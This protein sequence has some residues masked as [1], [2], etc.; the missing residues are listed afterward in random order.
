VP[1]PEDIEF[2]NRTAELHALRARIPPEARKAT[3]TF[4]RSPSGYGKTRLTDRLVES[5]LNDAPTYVIVDPA[6]RSKSR[7]DRIYG[8]FFVQRAA[9]L[10]AIKNPPKRRAFRTFSQF[11]RRTRQTR[12][13]WLHRYEDLKEAASLS[14][15]AKFIINLVENSLNLGRYRPDTL[16]EDDSPFATQIAQDYVRALANYRPTVFIVR[17]C[18][19]IDPE[20]LRFFLSVG[21]ETSHSAVIFEYTSTENKFLPEHQK[22]IFDTVAAKDDIIIFDLLRLDIEEFRL[23]LRK[24][25]PTDQYI[26]AAVELSWDG[27][28]RIIKELKYRLMIGHTLG[29]PDPVLLPETMQQNVDVLSKRQKLILAIVAG[30]VEAVGH[31]CLISVLRRIDPII[32]VI[33]VDS[34]LRTLVSTTRYLQ[35]EGSRIALA[36][37]DLL[38]ALMASVRMVPMLRIAETTLRDYYLDVVKGA[39]FVSMPLQSVFRQAIAL[40]AR[41]G[42]IVALRGLIRSLDSAILQAYDQTLYVNMVADAVLG[43]DDLSENEQRELVGWASAAAYEVGDFPTA[44]SLLERLRVPTPYDIALLAC[45]YGEVNRH[46]DALSLARNLAPQTEDLSSDAAVA[47]RLVECASLFALG[48]KDEASAVHNKLRF[49]SACSTSRLFGFVL[50]YTEIIRDFPGCT[51]DMLKSAK[52]LRMEGF[53]KASAYSQLAAAMH[54]SYAGDT[55]TARRL[56]S[57]AESELA[58]QVRDRQIL[59]NNYVVVELLSREPDVKTCL[60]RLN[61]ALFTVRDDFSR[62]VLQNNRLICYRLLGDIAK[63]THCAE[64]IDQILEAPAFGN[65]DVFWTVCFN[66]WSF[67]VEVG[68]FERAEWFRSIPRS[69]GINDWCYQQYWDVRF[70]QAKNAEPEFT[71]LLHHKYHPEYLSHWLIDLEGLAVLK[72]EYAR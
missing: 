57:N 14:K 9:E 20:S 24:Y 68:N 65:R 64:I 47:A 60:D 17:E 6:I 22:I 12:I 67:F 66:A 63:A 28:L 15:M 69:L 34:E 50:R 3:L 31:D 45:C 8:W 13:N 32:G 52:V 39:A 19:N 11:V 16:L 21:E 55:K 4:L 71:F 38:D 44:V 61:T 43:R 10:T 41:T 51:E 36:D 58:A 7:S 46:A 23:L 62:L 72:A 26:E 25:A 5:V 56:V 48:R 53:R 18:Q 70:G 54:L 29:G 49:D 2:V 37:E 59:L 30:N 1:R 42:D 33:E 35:I 40:C 27:N